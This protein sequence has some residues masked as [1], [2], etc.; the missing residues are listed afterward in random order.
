MPKTSE[1]MKELVE[2]FI[3]ATGIS[4]EDQTQKV[5][6]NSQIE[7]QFRVGA[8][9]IISKNAKRSDRIHIN[10]NM[11]F[12]PSDSRLL[13]MRDPRFSKT[14]MEVSEICTVCGVGHQWVKDKDSIAGLAIFS[15]VDEQSLERVPFHD[16]WDNVAR[17]TGHAQKI[18]RANFSGLSSQGGTSEE[19]SEKS[20]YG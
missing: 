3:R 10:V 8:N 14:V 19:T 13:D 12:P 7:W 15:H 5:P 6:E 11:R 18:L 17:V 1:E 20:M 2:E 16:A 4:Y 9:V